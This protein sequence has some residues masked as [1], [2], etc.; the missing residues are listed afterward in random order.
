MEIQSVGTI[1]TWIHE[2]CVVAA[3]THQEYITH[4][5]IHVE[6]GCEKG[7]SFRGYGAVGMLPR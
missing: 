2:R 7:I 4:Y 5:V 3:I 6:P 1:S